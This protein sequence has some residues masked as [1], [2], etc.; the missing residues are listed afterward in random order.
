MFIVKSNNSTENK[1][2]ENNYTDQMK[3]K[4]EN[5]NIEKKNSKA[6]IS[7]TAEER[8]LNFIIQASAPQGLS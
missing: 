2:A 4:F 7:G 8:S 1:R 5:N 6:L 3:L